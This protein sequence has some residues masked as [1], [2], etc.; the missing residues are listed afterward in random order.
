MPSV[1]D[2]RALSFPAGNRILSAIPEEEYGRILPHLT[3]VRLPRG[4]VLWD[5]GDVI[6]DAY[7]V[8]G[9]MLSLLSTT[10]EG[11]TIEVGMIGSEGLAGIAAVLG[12]EVAP[13][14]VVVQ[15]PAPALRV[16][17][18]A[19]R[20]EFARGGRLQLLLLR[21][22][23]ALLTQVSQSASCNRFHTVEERLCRWL[24]ISRD[25]AASDTLP[26]TQEFLSQMMGVPRTSVSAVAIQ[27]QKEGL[28]SYSRG[29]IRIIT[30]ADLRAAPASATRSSPQA[31]S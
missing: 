6:R 18:D 26:L 9:G 13:Y 8:A 24:L 17:V 25:R 11:S 20:R 1:K 14:G 29:V 15:I 7:F 27:L 10:G 22:T 2:P 4:K 23:H 3:P 31:S 21:Y 19:L 28:I 30:A 16:K 12:F 5:G